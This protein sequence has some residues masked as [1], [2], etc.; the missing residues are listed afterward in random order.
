MP[1]KKTAAAKPT[2]HNLKPLLLPRVCPKGHPV[3]S[4]KNGKE[5][6]PVDCAVGK[7]STEEEA[8]AR[9]VRTMIRDHSKYAV[10]REQT[11]IQKRIEKREAKGLSTDHLQSQMAVPALHETDLV[12]VPVARAENH[13]LALDTNPQPPTPTLLPIG[14][15]LSTAEAAKSDEVARLSGLAGNHAARMAFVGGLPKR[16][17]TEK[18]VAEWAEKKK[19]ELLPFAMSDV[20]IALKFGTNEERAAARKEVLQMNGFG[21]RES[22]PAQNAA[23]VVNLNGVQLPFMPKRLTDAQVVNAEIQGATSDTT[24]DSK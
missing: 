16:G 1:K 10:L 9:K 20:E 19:V 8:K 6:T 18:E 5:C 23:I 3:G 4:T 24:Q 14:S 13:A 2:T 15:D 17:A 11:A 21:A 12:S 22:N 7:L